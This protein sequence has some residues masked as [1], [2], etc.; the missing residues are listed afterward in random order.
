[1]E[2]EPNGTYSLGGRTYCVNMDMFAKNR[3]RLIA[4][5]KSVPE[6][7][8]KSFVLMKGGENSTVYSSNTEM[9]FRQ[10]SYFNWC[11]GV[12]EPGFYGVIDIDS[13]NSIL[14]VPR[15][16]D[17]HKKRA[18]EIN[19]LSFFE[20]KYGVSDCCYLDEMQVFFKMNM[21]S[22]IFILRGT[23]P[24]SGLPMLEP[25]LTLIDKYP[26]NDTLLHPK[27]TELRVIKTSDEISLIRYVCRVSSKAH[28]EV[29]RRVRPGWI[30]YQAESLFKHLAYSFGGCRNH[31]YISKVPTGFNGYALDY[32]NS[33]TPNSKKIQD[34]DMCV[35]DMGAEYH[36][37]G[38]AVSCSF[39]VNG[40]FSE[41]QRNIYSA[42]L[43]AHQAVIKEIK[44]GV[45]WADMHLLAERIILQEMLNLKLLFGDIDEMMEMRLATIFMPHGLGHFVGL[46]AWDVG[47]Y[48]PGFP[49]RRAEKGLDELYTCRVLRAGMVITVGP[50]IYFNVKVLNEALND[51]QICKYFH[52]RELANFFLFGGVRI[53]D[54]VA[55]TNNGVEVLTKVPREIKDVEILMAEGQ[56]MDHASSLLPTTKLKRFADELA[57]L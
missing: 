33:G 20:K 39:P 43:Q 16:P 35:F 45:P 53:E 8:E 49:P 48:L 7:E 55:V 24:Q 23:D 38:S 2:Q 14:F 17:S 56:R 37:Y 25:D 46:D 13:G 11:F 40:K 44:P 3:R 1:M 29:M 27:I 30:E 28:K 12:L 32:G 18:L 21:P 15:V 5:I 31:A 47:G 34:G 54:T 22:L 36:C 19:S 9:V 41:L 4:L 52:E 6:Y 50:A 26:V 10:E 57:L 51:P 42:V